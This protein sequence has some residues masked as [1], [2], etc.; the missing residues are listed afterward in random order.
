M[1]RSLWKLLLEN[2][3]KLT[4]DKC[5]A[6]LEYY[7]ELLAQGNVD[8]LP[9]VLEHLQGCPEC[10]RVHQEALRCLEAITAKRKMEQIDDNHS[11]ER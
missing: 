8:L 5:F 1:A 10:W 9:E 11:S 2:P 7:S 4:C 3:S 6:V